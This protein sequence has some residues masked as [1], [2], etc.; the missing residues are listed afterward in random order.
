MSVY[1]DKMTQCNGL[2]KSDILLC[3]DVRFGDQQ[4]S[5]MQREHCTNLTVEIN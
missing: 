5:E 1:R 4:L 2:V 3:H